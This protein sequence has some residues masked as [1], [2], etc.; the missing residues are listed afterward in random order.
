METWEE[1]DNEGEY[2]ESNLALMASIF[3]NSK[4]EVDS[5]FESE[6]TN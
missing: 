3:S 4:S 1:L 5:D 2:E 6:D